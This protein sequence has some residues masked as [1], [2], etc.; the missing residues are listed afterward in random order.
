M[1][2]ICPTSVTYFG[3][4]SNSYACAYKQLKNDEK[5]IAAKVFQIPISA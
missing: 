1:A 5:C 2:Q 4:D 3:N